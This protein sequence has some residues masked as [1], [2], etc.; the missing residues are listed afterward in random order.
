MGSNL[1]SRFPFDDVYN[2]S[3]IDDIVG[4]RYDLVVSAGNRAD[5]FR[6]NRNGDDDL[7]EVDSLADRLDQVEITQLVLVSTVCVYPGASSPDETAPL[8]MADLT[9]YGAN[10]L[11]QE[12]RL[13][14]AHDTLVLRLPQLYGDGLKKGIIY[15]LAHDYRVEFIRPDARFQYYDVRRL[16][17]DLRAALDARLS[18][19]NLAT[20]AIRNDVIAREA[21]GIDVSGNDP[22][23]ADPFADMYTR[24]MRT[25]HAAAFGGADG[26]LMDEERELAEIVAFAR[27]LREDS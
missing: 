6:I 20:P 5:S 13:A 10:R 4:K 27:S 25:I 18:S 3:N 16:A 11:H 8:D 7:R 22:G 21:F 23:P 1:A 14:A 26:Y 15:D 2:T 19:L 9:P 12:Q 24:D 17:D